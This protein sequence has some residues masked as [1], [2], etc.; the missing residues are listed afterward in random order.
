MEG[1]RQGTGQQEP[2]RMVVVDPMRN[3]PK[4]SGEKTDQQ[5]IILM[6]VMV[7]WKYSKLMFLMPMWHKS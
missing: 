5:T 4:F 6:H 3:L 1:G 2:Q 7:I